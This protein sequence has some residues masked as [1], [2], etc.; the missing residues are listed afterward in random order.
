MKWIFDFIHEITQKVL[1]CVTESLHWISWICTVKCTFL[2]RN[3]F[4]W[5]W[6][7]ISIQHSSV[8]YDITIDMIDTG[9][10]ILALIQT[11]CVGKRS[12]PRKKDEKG[13]YLGYLPAW[14]TE[15]QRQT[16]QNKPGSWPIFEF[17]LSC[18]SWAVHPWWR[19]WWSLHCQTEEMKGNNKSKVAAIM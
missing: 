9:P 11:K 19:W 13:R 3:S 8:S 4:L 16:V 1:E 5:V 10:Y 2:L 6:S 15:C 12:L 14:H 18:I 17:S 7:P